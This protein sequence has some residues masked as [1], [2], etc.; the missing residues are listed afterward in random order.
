MKPWCRHPAIRP[1]RAGRSYEESRPQ[2]APGMTGARWVECSG[3]GQA[4]RLDRSV[5]RVV[6]ATVERVKLREVGPAARALFLKRPAWCR[7][8]VNRAQPP[9]EDPR[10]RGQSVGAGFAWCRFPL[11]TYVS[12]NHDEADP[13]RPCAVQG[14]RR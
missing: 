5:G 7:E 12:P 9:V 10:K 4:P 2:A 11:G 3:R 14:V 1:G 8:S 6:P 13:A